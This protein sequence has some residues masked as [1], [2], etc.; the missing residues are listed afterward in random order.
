MRLRLLFILLI[1]CFVG[2]VAAQPSV[3]YEKAKEKTKQMLAS[4]N[5]GREWFLKDIYIS[6]NRITK[7]YIIHRELPFKNGD[8]IHADRLIA[9][10]DQARFNLMN[11]NL[12]LEATPSIDSINDTELI[13]RLTLKERWYIFPL[14][15]FK[16]ID[17]NLNQWLI[18]QN[19]SLE[20]VNYGIKFTWENM[21]GRRDQLRFNV[22]NGYSREFSLF[23][24][25]PYSGKRLEH[26][27]YVGFGYS[28]Q[29]QMMYSTEDHKQIFYPRI[30]DPRS[31][32]VKST[33]VY[34]LGY[35]Y[36]KG[37]RFR[38]RLGVRYVEEEISD[39][40]SLLISANAAKGYRPFFPGNNTTLSFAQIDYN[41]QFLNLNNNAYPWQG[42]GLS[43]GLT[44]RGFG[45]SPLQLWQ[46]N[47]KV[48]QYWKI[49]AKNSFSLSG[50]GILKIPFDQPMYNLPFLG[51]GDWYLR[52]LEYYVID[53]V[54]GGILSASLRR[55]VLNLNV[56]TFFI[57]SEKYKKIPFKIIAKAFID[58]GGA[59]HPFSNRWVLNNR[60]LLTYGFGVD[61][62]SYYD[63]I[64][65]IE[66]SF[67][68]L[69]ENG[70]FL[71]VRREF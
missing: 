5:A 70:L 56:P 29:R 31:S 58:Q 50:K 40:V 32:F 39:S 61:V 17:R 2:S 1:L 9:L 43:A 8:I 24:E 30:I 42:I 37:V 23:Y 66:C 51:Y 63:F 11:T 10:F 34:E 62:L 54:A 7:N 49:G 60:W 45:L 36:R 33:Y 20:R 13:I 14:P 25:K 53:G 18:E 68:Q 55:E 69:G 19:A 65:Q 16:F 21:S 59:H 4:Y 35:T 52:G 12:F 28:R 27:Y 67:N 48:A 26:G 41:F 22:I 38:H 3:I 46:L 44:H 47:V 64:S 6:G 15:Y 71:H 57:K